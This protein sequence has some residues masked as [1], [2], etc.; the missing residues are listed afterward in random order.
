MIR[1]YLFSYI[2]IFYVSFVN[3]TF[4][5]RH[6]TYATGMD[7]HPHYQRHLTYATGMDGSYNLR[8]LTDNTEESFIHMYNNY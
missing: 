6:L 5:L 7:D 4:N 2:I 3:A 8:R 1:T